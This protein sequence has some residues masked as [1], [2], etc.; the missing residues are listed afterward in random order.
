MICTVDLNFF[1]GML[2]L[3]QCCWYPRLLREETDFFSGVVGRLDLPKGMLAPF[4][5]KFYPG[6]RPWPAF[7]ERLAFEFQH[8]WKYLENPLLFI[9]INFTPKNQQ[10][11]YRFLPKKKMYFPMFSRIWVY[12]QPKKNHHFFQWQPLPG[13]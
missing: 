4:C 10:L 13:S 2:K 7:F 11:F 6:S 12:H 1:E 9:F 3:N 8:F 5:K